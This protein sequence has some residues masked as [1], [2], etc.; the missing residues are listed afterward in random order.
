MYH[1][2]LYKQIKLTINTLA[3]MGFCLG[4]LIMGMC[5]MLGLE[6]CFEEREGIVIQK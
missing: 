3:N 6:S 2:R 4:C 5:T 1:N